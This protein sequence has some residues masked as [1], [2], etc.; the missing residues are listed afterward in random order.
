MFK[1]IA[2]N[3]RSGH[4]HLP[5]IVSLYIIN[6]LP[7]IFALIIGSIGRHCYNLWYCYLIY[8]L[9]GQFCSELTHYHFIQIVYSIK[10]NVCFLAAVITLYVQNNSTLLF[11]LPPPFA[12]SSDQSNLVTFSLSMTLKKLDVYALSSHFCFFFECEHRCSAHV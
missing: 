5:C 4:F 9:V 8:Q 12:S 6:P 2:S 11:P 7:L 1:D 3:R 10:F